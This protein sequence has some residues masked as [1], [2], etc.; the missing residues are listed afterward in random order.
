MGSRKNAGPTPWMS[1]MTS[2][3]FLA[4]I[5]AQL[6]FSFSV[7]LMQ[8]YLPTFLKQV[9][10]VPLKFNGIFAILPFIMQIITKNIVSNI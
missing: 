5:I 1:I 10:R 3:P 9:L 2:K 4:A 6:S 8:T 7:I